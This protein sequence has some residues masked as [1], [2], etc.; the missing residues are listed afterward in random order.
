VGLER[1]PLSLVS[2]NDNLLERKSSGYGL[3]KRDYGRRGSAAMTSV[4]QQKLALT[5][6]S[7][8]TW[9]GRLYI[10][11]P[12]YF[13]DRNPYPYHVEGQSSSLSLFLSELLA[14]D[15]NNLHSVILFC[16]TPKI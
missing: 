12:S 1:G 5:S 14:T 16:E 11:F 10:C 9:R 4:Y 3:E 7:F 8:G 6:P 2:T 15:E 13:I